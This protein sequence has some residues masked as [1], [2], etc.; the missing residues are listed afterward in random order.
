LVSRLLFRVAEVFTVKGRGICLCPGISL[1]DYRSMK[2]GDEIELRAPASAARRVTIQALVYPPS[3][4]YVGAEPPERTS[5]VMLPPG[6]KAED[7]PVGT[8]VWLPTA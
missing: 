6:L 2:P 5:F 8:E 3:I 7:V 1:Q 4:I